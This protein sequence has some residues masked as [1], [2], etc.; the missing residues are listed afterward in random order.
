MQSTLTN[1]PAD[2]LANKPAD[3]PC[4]VV[5]IAPDAVRVAP[6]GDELTD[7]LQQAAR[8]RD[9]QSG[10]SGSN[11]R[12][13][14][15]APE[16]SAATIPPVD[17]TFR[18]SVHDG[19]NSN[20]GSMGRSAARGLVALVLAGCIGFV[21]MSWKSYGDVVIKKTAK[22]ATML[23]LTPSLSSESTASAAPP[24]TSDVQAD[25]TSSQ[26]AAPAQ[27]AP[28]TAASADQTQL[29]KSMARDLANLG[30]EVELLKAGMEQLK[31]SQQQA[32]RD[33]AKVSDKPS[34]RASAPIL[35]TTVSAPPKPV[36]VAPPRPRR[37]VASYS[38]PQQQY[39]PPQYPPS[40][41]PA[42]QA[43]AAPPLPPTESPYVSR[44]APYVPRQVEPASQ[45]TVGQVLTDPELASVP[46]PPMPVR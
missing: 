7:L 28:D 5:M 1:K 41:Y 33:V 30:Q 14:A 8:Q 37:P 16:S 29:L 3:D 22:M 35:R 46:R 36:P 40:Q 32:S 27:T 11:A 23:M 18:P 24:A 9:P 43:A 21:A 45:T 44:E 26:A 17:T 34:D 13:K 15:A 4:D 20:R 38:P 2:E 10:L 31:S 6:A 19:L 42:P 25:A 39:P 12:P